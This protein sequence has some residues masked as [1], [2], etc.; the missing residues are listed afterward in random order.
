MKVK[1]LFAWNDLWMGA[2][3]DKEIKILYICPLPTIVI[4]LV[5][6][7]KIDPKEALRNRAKE[8]LHENEYVLLPDK[9]TG[10]TI[11]YTGKNKEMNHRGKMYI[12]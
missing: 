12:H 7:T 8:F 6:K 2:Y 11:S 9:V 1:L 5:F 3:W 10:M 4:I